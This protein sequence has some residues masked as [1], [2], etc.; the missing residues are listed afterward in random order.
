[1]S[2]ASRIPPVCRRPSLRIVRSREGRP[3][4]AMTA[5]DL[6]RLFE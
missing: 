5:A 4:D 1:M 3:V 6:H 2:F